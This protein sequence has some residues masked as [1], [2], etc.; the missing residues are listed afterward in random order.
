ME[1]K[2]QILI[3][4]DADGAEHDSALPQHVV[5]REANG[6]GF[7]GG[8]SGGTAGGGWRRFDNNGGF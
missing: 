8:L 7:A 5:A 4:P 2:K 6:G 1:S 3:E